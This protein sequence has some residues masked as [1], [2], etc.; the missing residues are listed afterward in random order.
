MKIS[1]RYF[2]A[3]DKNIL[4]IRCINY[5]VIFNYFKILEANLIRLQF[6]TLDKISL[7]IV[8][9]LQSYHENMNF[10]VVYF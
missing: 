5:S 4:L 10:P 6:Q 7:Y 9:I 3:N 8:N 2:V 1:N